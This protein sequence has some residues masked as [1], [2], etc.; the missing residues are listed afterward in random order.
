MSEQFKA[1]KSNFLGDAP[2]W[3][4]VV[5]I[6]F[7]IINPILL[8][9]TNSYI[10]GWVVVL[11][12]IFCLAMALQCYPL[13]SGGL[14]AMQAIFLGLSDAYHVYH[15]IE[16]NLK[17]IL[18]LM[19]MVAGIYFMKDLLLYLFSKLLTNVKSKMA[20]SAIFLCSSAFLSA[21]LD[22]LTVIAVIIAVA[23]GFYTIYREFSIEDKMEDE[24]LD[25]SEGNITR[26]FQVE[27]EKFR[28]FLRSLLM[29]AAIGSTLGGVATLVGEPQ[30]VVIADKAGWD[31]IEFLL[32]M[33]PISIPVFFAGLLTCLML[34]KAKIFGYGGKLPD[35]VRQIIA[36]S[37]AEKDAK[38]TTR[39][40]QKLWI[41]A[42]VGLWLIIGLALHLAE[43]GIIG[44]TVIILATAFTGVVQEHKLGH[45]F[46]EALPFTALLVVFF[47]I[48]AIIDSQKLFKPVIEYVLT[49]SG[50]NQITSFFFANGI[51]SA[52][53]DNVFVGTVYIKELKQALEAG[54]IERSQFDLL[55]VAVNAGTNIP[56]IATPN[57]QAAFLFLLT[58]AI[59]PKI[60]LGYMTMVYMAIP[61]TIILTIIAW[62][63]IHNF[64]EPATLEML[65]QGIIG[66]SD[67]AKEIKGHH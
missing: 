52:I 16:A 66:I 1:L 25:A 61:Y 28:S 54:L 53:S 56:S 39:D 9:T 58:S 62:I 51:L 36:N 41:Q 19:F 15:E 3:F 48:V 4:K 6:A 63:A 38:R 18:L 37:A 5:I 33:A 42:I 2:N 29:H 20:L 27:M 67:G 23:V 7:L 17:V 11:E 31:F 14:I 55:A 8:A 21:F 32:R 10:T 59:A 65:H 43:V 12:F 64:L 35:E 46:E 44:L 50:Q 30:N 47:A 13:Q 57:G 26:D 60:R 40:R 34:E 22:A 45:A 24:A 49:L